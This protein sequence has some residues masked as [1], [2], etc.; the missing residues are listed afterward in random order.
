MYVRIIQAAWI[1]RCRHHIIAAR[2]YRGDGTCR[3]P[4]AQ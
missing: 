2:H 4:A 3:C 1:S